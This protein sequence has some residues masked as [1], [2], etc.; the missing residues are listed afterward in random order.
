MNAEL[1]HTLEICQQTASWFG[2]IIHSVTDR[3]D[4]DNTPL[5]TVCTWGEIDP[6]KVLLDAGA[7]INAKGEHGMTPIFN[8]VISRN[9]AL[10]D[11]LLKNGASKHC[12]IFGT[13]NL[14]D[15]AKSTN[16]SK[17]ILELLK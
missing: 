16:S 14:L 6:V 3:N 2:I 7:D 1:K 9:P 10:V 13:K 15:Y 8:A 12:K 17:Q 11:F 5:H 4:F